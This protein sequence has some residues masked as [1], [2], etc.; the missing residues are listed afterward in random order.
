MK[1]P[2][3]YTIIV[4]SNTQ[5]PFW[6]F[7]FSRKSLKI[8]QVVSL[9]SF[10]G[11]CLLLSDYI[12]LSSYQV[13]VHLLR[14][15]L[16]KTENKISM[17]ESHLDEMGKDLNQIQNVNRK[18]KLLMSMDVE[19]ESSHYVGKGRT[20]TVHKKKFSPVKKEGSYL[21]L[22]SQV[23]DAEPSVGPY[24]EFEDLQID[25]QNLKEESLQVYSFLLDRENLLKFTP[26]ILPVKQGWISSAYG[27][28]Q[29][30][31]HRRKDPRFHNGIDIAAH[32]G[33]PI[34]ATADGCVLYKGYDELGYGNLVIIDHGH[35]VKTYYAHLSSINS[36]MKRCVKRGEVI[37][38]VGSTGRSTGAH[39][40]YEIRVNNKA[41]DPQSYILDGRSFD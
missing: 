38:F 32:S 25:S 10:F 14:S 16:L 28:R 35:S 5:A 18:V 17:L 24:N 9:S 20:N 11:L 33:S 13:E 40:H 15:E 39:L 22:A 6:T 19:D 2:K 31:L 8:F 37:G 29:S 23:G 36:R 1:K 30:P 4:S 26:S 34:M 27:F 7:R 12:Q 21:S 3:F 41:V